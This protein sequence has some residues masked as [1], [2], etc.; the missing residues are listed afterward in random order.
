MEG[1]QAASLCSVLLLCLCGLTVCRCG[2]LAELFNHTVSSDATHAAINFFWITGDVW[3][4]GPE[5][6]YAAHY[7]AFWRF[8]QLSAG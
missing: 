6:P 4:H 1:V 7:V 8:P 3:A 5:S 2:V